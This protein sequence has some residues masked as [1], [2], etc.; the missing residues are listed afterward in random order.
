MMNRTKTEKDRVGSV[1][2]VWPA[3][4]A[5]ARLRRVR[6]EPILARPPIRAIQPCT[7]SRSDGSATVNSLAWQ[8]QNGYEMAE[9]TGWF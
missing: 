7:R 9:D 3:W 2:P 4:P 8:G 1:R 6:V 5:A